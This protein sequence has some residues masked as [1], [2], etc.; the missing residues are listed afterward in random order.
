MWSKPARV[1]I[2]AALTVL[3]QLPVA[4]ADQAGGHGDRPAAIEAV[5][6]GSISGGPLKATSGFRAGSPWMKPEG[7]S[8]QT[9]TAASRSSTR[10]VDS[11]THV[12]RRQRRPCVSSVSPLRSPWTRRAWCM[13]LMPS[14]P[15]SRSSRARA[16]SCGRG[17]R[18][19]AGRASSGNPKESRSIATATCSSQIP[20]T[21]GCR[22][23]RPTAASCEPGVPK[24]AGTASSCIRRI[25]AAMAMV[26]SAL[27]W[28]TTETSMSPIIELS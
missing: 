11:F 19:E 27:P 20:S 1:A 18:K 28:L 22:C 15:G 9:A 26:R 4:G 23:S 5:H 12:G 2:V 24:E 25:Q 8:W 21:T 17:V 6:L 13:W 14:T 7:S 3:L 16:C 10:M